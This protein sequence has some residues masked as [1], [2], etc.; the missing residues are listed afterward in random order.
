MLSLI[1]KIERKEDLKL[2]A[3]LMIQHVMRGRKLARIKPLTEDSPEVGDYQS[4]YRQLKKQFRAISKE[5]KNIC[6]ED[7]VF[8][9]MSR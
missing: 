3:V 1:K 5:I 4:K 6:E 7:D 9:E 2:C 8:E